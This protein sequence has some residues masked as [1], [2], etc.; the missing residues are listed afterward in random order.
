MRKCKSGWHLDDY[1]GHEGVCSRC[2]LGLGRKKMVTKI[3]EELL[4]FDG[5][6]RGIR[7]EQERAIEILQGLV[8]EF[9]RKEELERFVAVA[10]RRLRDDNV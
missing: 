7:S 3:Q 1:E 4:K 2:I 9:D 6:E 5:Y 8:Q 10:I